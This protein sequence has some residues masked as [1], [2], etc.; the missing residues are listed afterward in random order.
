MLASE[1]P[2]VAGG[3]TRH[4]AASESDGKATAGATAVRASHCDDNRPL[5]REPAPPA[6]MPSQVG[7]TLADPSVPGL[8]VPACSAAGSSLVYCML[9]R[10]RVRSHVDGRTVNELRAVIGLQ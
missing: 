4:V 2:A 9:S 10:V 8:P 5:V 6:H 7:R 3:L 1:F